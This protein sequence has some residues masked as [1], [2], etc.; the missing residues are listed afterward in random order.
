MSIKMLFPPT[1][2]KVNMFS[3]PRVNREIKFRTERNIEQYTEKSDEDIKARIKE[4]DYEW[5]TE[6][7]LEVNFAL[8]VVVT[9]FIGAIRN[10]KWSL[11]STIAAVFM[12]QHSLQGWCPPLSVIRRLGVRTATEILEEKETLKRVLNQRG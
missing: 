9:T 6:R 4:L 12:L 1:T 8:I 5:D 7:T 11:I 10:K 2:T 3:S